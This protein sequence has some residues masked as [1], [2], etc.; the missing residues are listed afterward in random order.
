MEKNKSGCGSC[1]VNVPYM[2]FRLAVF[3]LSVLFLCCNKGTD[4]VTK[5]PAP[6]S[7]TSRYDSIYTC[8][9]Y[10]NVTLSFTINVTNGDILGNPVTYTVAGLPPTIT[11]TPVT[12]TVGGVMG[13]AFTLTLGNI[14][15]GTYLAHFIISSKVTG[16]DSHKLILNVI[17]PIDYAPLM[18][19]TYD[20]AYDFCYPDSFFHY[21]SVVS[22]VA[23]TPYLVKISNIKKLGAGFK[24][25]AWLNKTITVPVQYVGGYTIWGSGSYFKDGAGYSMRIDDTLVKGI[26][27]QRCTIHIED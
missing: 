3:L 1:L 13:G 12:Q 4:T 20:S 7:F 8:Y 11:A 27:T 2:K 23:D 26:D 6:F 19:G 15:A 16:V 5:P 14:A 22:A 21:T 17:P 25:R 9:P 24:I 10:S 18:A